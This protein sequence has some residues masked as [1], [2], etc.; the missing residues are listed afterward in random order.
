M[1]DASGHSWM[2]RFGLPGWAETVWVLPEGV[3]HDD[4]DKEPWEKEFA[5][6]FFGEWDTDSDARQTLG[7]LQLACFGYETALEDDISLAEQMPDLIAALREG[8]LVIWGYR[9]CAV[10]APAVLPNQRPVVRPEPK[11]KTWI[12]IVLLDQD[13]RPV[14][15]EPYQL[16][17]PDGATRSGNLDDNGFVR[18][19]GIVP[20][21]C[22]VSFPKIDARECGRST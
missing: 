21:S 20:G 5:D 11:V 19:E 7:D 10:A 1:S 16:T 17:L 12:E 3:P 18:V 9:R 4:P 15:R 6:A 22:D 13:G 14:P 2:W 8:R